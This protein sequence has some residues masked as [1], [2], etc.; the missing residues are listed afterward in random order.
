MH[1]VRGWAG[2]TE[3][4]AHQEWILSSR[5]AQGWRSADQAKGRVIGLQPKPR[6]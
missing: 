6:Y 5:S 3:S 1:L 2:R 4:P